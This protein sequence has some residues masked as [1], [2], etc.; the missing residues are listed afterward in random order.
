MPEIL[1]LSQMD[2]NFSIL[3][4]SV[5]QKVWKIFRF[6]GAAMATSDEHQRLMERTDHVDSYPTINK[7]KDE[8]EKKIKPQTH[9]QKRG[10]HSSNPL[11]LN[12]KQYFSNG[13]AWEP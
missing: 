9:I 10:S 6:S 4:T 7:V 3:T 8:G 12:C 13:T 2:G 5:M 1:G 11:K